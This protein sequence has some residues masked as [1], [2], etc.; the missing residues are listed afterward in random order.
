MSDNAQ[1]SPFTRPGFIAAAIV[2]LLIVV[3]GGIAVI[4][5]LTSQGDPDP[6]PTGT[7][8]P[9]PSAEDESVCGLEDF[10]TESSLTEA[11]DNEWELVG[12]VAAPTDPEVGPGVVDDDGFRT[13]FAHTA[14]GALYAAANYVALSSDPRLQPRIWMLL[15]EGP[16]RDQAE[17]DSASN[18][19]EPS[20]SRLQVAGFRVL[21]YSASTA[22][23][24]VAWQVTSP[25][26]GLISM[27]IEFTWQEGDWRLATTD[28]GLPY[29]PSQLQSLGGYIPWSGA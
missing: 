14:E 10:E 17:A 27:P 28:T 22:I 12:T 3:A 2:V 16:V 5:G 4:V 19:S 1:P 15:E 6:T 24:D 8:G 9:G 7:T 21:E 26:P 11:P 13:C 20:S 18:P 23:I 29:S 25:T